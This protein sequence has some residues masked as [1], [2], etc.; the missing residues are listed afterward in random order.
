MNEKR[1]RN[2]AGRSE[3]TADKTRGELAN[4]SCRLGMHWLAR[5]RRSRHS[6]ATAIDGLSLKETNRSRES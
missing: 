5:S 2:Q 3:R 6:P 4:S 1:V